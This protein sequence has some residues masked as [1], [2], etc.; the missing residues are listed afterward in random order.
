MKYWL[1]KAEPNSRIVKG[2]DVK[3]SVDDFEAVGTTAW[4]G[5]R[6]FEARNLMKDMSTGDKVLFYHSN[7]KNPGIAGFAEVCK[8]TYPDYTAW[9]SSHP[10]YDPKT[11][12]ETPKWFM[13]DVKFVF[14]APHFVSLSLLRRIAAVSSHDT[15]EAVAYVGSDGLKAIKEMALLNRGRLSVQRVSEACWTAIEEMARRGGWGDTSFSQ[16]VKA[17]SIKSDR[18]RKIAEQ[19]SQ[20]ELKDGTGRSTASDGPGLESRWGTSRRGCKRK[21]SDGDTINA[22]RKSARTK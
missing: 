8:E 7:C 2:K 16:K 18:T 1:M 11:N 9:D 4:E 21:E 3:F 19:D 22:R 6:N 17:T 20:E 10:Y 12:K 13:V 15:L 14:R 5:V